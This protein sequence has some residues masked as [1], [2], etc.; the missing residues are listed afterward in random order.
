MIGIMRRK[1]ILEDRILRRI[2]R[3]KSAVFL[4]EDFG[5]MAGYDQVG[6]ALRNLTKKGALMNVGYGLYAKTSVSPFNGEI[7]PVKNLP[8]LAKEALGRLG[9]Q[10]LP[11]FYEREYNAGRSTQ[12]PTGRRIGV[13]TRIRRRIGYNGSY[14]SYE[15]IP[16]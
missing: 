10:T 6:R 15:R 13:T 5:D 2:S 3:K 16:Q 11:S 4:R 1:R 14:I 7:V 9:V 8:S 12:V